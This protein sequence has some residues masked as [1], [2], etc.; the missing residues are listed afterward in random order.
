MIRVFGVPHFPTAGNYSA[1]IILKEKPEVVCVELHQ[2]VLEDLIR[3]VKKKP[4]ERTRE[5]RRF[6]RAERGDGI[7]A[8]IELAW[9]VGAEVYGL[10]PKK[11]YDIYRSD[12]KT[13]LEGKFW[14][15]LEKLWKA[16]AGYSDR[17]GERDPDWCQRSPWAPRIEDV[18][19]W[20]WKH[21]CYPAYERVSLQRER[22][23]A[24]RLIHLE[25]ERGKKAKI[26]FFVG[27][28]HKWNTLKEIN[29][30]RTVVS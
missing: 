30:K 16:I 25:R 10:E 19:R 22:A 17:K 29:R 28:G 5:E 3:V 7:V 12:Y 23:Y 21:E 11:G 1:K 26:F 24:S 18:R 14:R 27:Y 8:I 13:G 15:F 2:S 9:R 20:I 4:A 6:Y